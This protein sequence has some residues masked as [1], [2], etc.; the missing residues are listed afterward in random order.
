[1]NASKVSIQQ[2]LKNH[3]IAI[4]SLFI[5][6]SSLAYN[7]WRNE[8]TEYNRNVR[9]SS[10]EVLMSL[11]QLQLL[12]DYAF[13]DDNNTKQD[14]IKGWSYVL[15]MEDLAQTISPQTESQI[16]D[17]KSTWQQH[18]QQVDNNKESVDLLTKEISES[19]KLVLKTLKQ[20]H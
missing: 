17:L 4:I 8:V 15:Y 19:R 6:V 10:F 3:L 13:Y 7:T 16:D 1:M 18:W 5:A 12:I 20:L 14:P 11:T 9:T 2:Q